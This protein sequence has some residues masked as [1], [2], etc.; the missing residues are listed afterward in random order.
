[1]FFVKDGF[2]KVSA[3]TPTVRTADSGFNVK[4]ILAMIAEL[5]KD[6]ALAVFPELCVTGNTCG[7]LF[8]QSALLNGAEKA[9]GQL[10]RSTVDVDTVI[11][12]GVPIAHE[13]SLYNCAAI[14]CHGNLLGLVPK[15]SLSSKAYHRCFASGKG[16]EAVLRYADQ[17]TYLCS[18]ALFDCSSVS[19]FRLGVE[20][21][22]DLFGLDPVS[23]H[24]AQCGATVIACLSADCQT[25]ER[26]DLRSQ[27]VEVQS[28]RLNVTYVYANAGLGESVSDLVFAGGNKIAECG[29]LIAQSKPFTTQ[30]LVAVTDLQ[31]VSCEQ[32]RQ[33]KNTAINASVVEF[34]LPMVETTFVS[35]VPANPFIPDSIPAQQCR[36][37]EILT[38]QSAAL[39]QR[40]VHTG[41]DA[42]LG[43]S[44]GLDS[45]L[46]LFVTVRAYAL[47]KRENSG[48]CAV[49]MP[50]F[51]TTDRTYQNACK[52]ANEL[53]TSLREIPIAA[54]VRQ[55]LSD[56]SHDGATDVTYENA[57]A[58]E[59]TQVLMDVANQVRGLVVG[60]GDMSE[61]ALGW[62]TYNGDHMSM[63]GV[64]AG[65]PKTLVRYLVQYEADRFTGVVQ[66][67]LK[68]ILD[69][70]VSPE[71]LP[72]ENGVIAQKTE[73]LVGD[74]RLH[75]FFLYHVVRYGF[76]PTK[77]YRLACSA[78]EGVFETAEIKKWMIVFYKRFFAQQFKRNCLP[79]GPKVGSV[80]LSPRGDLYMPSD[81]CGD[82]WIRE[83]ESL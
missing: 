16:V 12:V 49:T 52:L 32:R 35:N 6:T 9:V 36:F 70:P 68:D 25:V 72:P 34:S 18:T 4:Q 20:F 2:F 38:I 76:S 27:F 77:I 1:M 5:P 64:N 75:D 11:V 13:G 54:A 3:L 17:D 83:A 30:P 66:T 40:L 8:W 47:L 37:E 69:T 55:H 81:A 60:T 71:L 28:K 53:G 23:D 15:L 59:R 80:C 65:V 48:I 58:R 61:L 79:D 19:Q 56:I 67:V 78:F 44:G 51:G 41:C 14:C 31:R 7:D 73:S 57:Q 62:A 82:L 10:L 42:V 39:A 26:D 74:Y 43:L 46:A 45:A 21:G 63:Y 50:C 24:L 33:N 29:T 22:D